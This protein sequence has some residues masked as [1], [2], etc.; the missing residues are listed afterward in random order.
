MRQR[1]R[2]AYERLVAVSDI[3]LVAVGTLGACVVVA[4]IY[5]R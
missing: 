1:I 5:L 3:L 2:R 4:V